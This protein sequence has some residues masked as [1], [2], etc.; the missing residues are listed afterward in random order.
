MANGG[1]DWLLDMSLAAATAFV[2]AYIGVK[3]WLT[4][5]DV[6]LEEVRARVERMEDKL[7]RL[8]ESR[9]HKEE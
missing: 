5:H 2:S 6:L 7:D 8:I 4:R 9:L 1:R 3:V